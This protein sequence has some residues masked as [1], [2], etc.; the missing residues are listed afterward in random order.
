MLAESSFP[1]LTLDFHPQCFVEHGHFAG[2]D[3]VRLSALLDCA[4]D[5]TVD[6]VWFARGGYGSNRIAAAAIAGMNRAAH[7][8]SYLGYSDCG[9]LLGAL[10]R[11]R[12]GRP[13]HGPV[14]ADVRRGDGASEGVAASRALAWLSGSIEGI[15]P[16]LDGARPTVAFNLMTLAMLCGTDLM[17]DLSGHIVMVEEV[18]EYLYAVD[19]LFFAL[20]PYLTG[21]AGLRLGAVSDVPENDRPFGATAEE[22]AQYWC[23]RAQVP[24]LGRAE[25]GHTIDNRIVPFGL[26]VQLAGA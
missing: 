8:K 26:A 12:I 11:H 18:G 4:N 1:A 24:Y 16:T 14:V 21:V 17:P 23:V 15:E 20:M 6:A 25:I 9:Y 13:V 2:D 22:I 10:Y 19:R 3:E 5:P 7:E